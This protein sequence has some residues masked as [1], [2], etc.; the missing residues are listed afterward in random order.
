MPNRMVY[1]CYVTG[2]QTG[3]KPKK[4]IKKKI[5]LFKFPADKVLRGKCI[6][7]VPQKN[8]KITCNSIVCALHFDTNDF[9]TISTDKKNRCQDSLA[10]MQIRLKPMA[11]SHIFPNLPQYLSKKLSL[12]LLLLLLLQL[13]KN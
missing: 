12:V 4:T 6:R 13:V 10:L 2:C 11:I 3:Y 9:I 8:S 7:A 5:P 1:T